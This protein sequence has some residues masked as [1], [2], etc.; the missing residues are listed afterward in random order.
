MTKGTRHLGGLAIIVVGVLVAPSI[1][2]A[3]DASAARYIYEA[4]LDTDNNPITGGPVTVVQ[5]TETPH[6]EVGIDYI[7]RV[8]AEAPLPATFP[9]TAPIVSGP[10]VLNR[11]VL[12]WNATTQMFDLI[13]CNHTMYPLGVGPN[14]EGLVEW[15]APLKFIGY[16]SGTIRGVFHASQQDF[17][18]YTAPFVVNFPVQAPAQSRGGLALLGA[19]LLVSAVYVLGRRQRRSMLAVFVASSLAIGAVAWAA[20]IVLDGDFADW[21][22]IAP[23][24]TDVAGDSSIHDPAEDILAGYAV[25]EQGSIFFRMDLAG[26]IQST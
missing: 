15:G 2:A 23:V 21:T 24:V 12:K 22:G 16:P 25:V 8:G 18:D 7:V 14:G 5:D 11:D 10:E 4:L 26:Q 19:L 13:D 3:T 6:D 9:D 17:N 1:A 20:A